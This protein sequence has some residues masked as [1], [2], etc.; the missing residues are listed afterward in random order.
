[1]SDEEQLE[2][3]VTAVDGNR[4]TLELNGAVRKAL[5]W[6]D[7]TGVTVHYQGRSYDFLDLTFQP[8]VTAEAAGGDGKVRA[9][10]N[11]NIVSVDIAVGDRVEKGQKLVVVEAMKM[12]HTH[13]SM[14][15]GT[16]MAVNVTKGMQVSTH[17]ILVEIDAA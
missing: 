4:I 14:V 9:S 5:L 11:G 7:E 13:A 15:S 8:T 12:E 17:A 10:M 6:R 2:L 16:V 3:C 1:M